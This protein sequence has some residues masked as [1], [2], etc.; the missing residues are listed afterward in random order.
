MLL[1]AAYYLYQVQRS[2][3]SGSS[4]HHN[5]EEKKHKDKH[6]EKSFDM[7]LLKHGFLKLSRLQYSLEPNPRQVV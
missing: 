3:R 4:V 6:L 1:V 7:V 2:P 5:H